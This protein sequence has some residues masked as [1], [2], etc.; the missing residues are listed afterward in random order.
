VN[1]VPV[2]TQRRRRFGL[3]VVTAAAVVL[4][5]WIVFLATR[6]PENHRSHEWRTAWVGFDIALVLAFAATAWFGWRGR[7]VVI[8]AL[9]VTAVLLLCDTWF[10]VV[11]SWGGRGQWSAVVA[12]VLVEIPLAVYM[13]VVHHR[14]VRTLTAQ[15]WRDQGRPGEPPPLRDVPLLVRNERLEALRLD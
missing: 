4:V 1:T 10:D 9:V 6:L 2:A 15:I 11:L 8:T 12:A 7:Q 5:P 13:L 3:F 14:L